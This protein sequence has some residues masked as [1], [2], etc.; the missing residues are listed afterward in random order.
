MRFRLNQTISSKIALRRAAERMQKRMNAAVRLQHCWKRY[1][2]MKLLGAEKRTK[3]AGMRRKGAVLMQAIWRGYTARKKR[4]CTGKMETRVCVPKLLTLG[5]RLETALHQLLHGRR[6]AEVLLASHTIQVCTQY[7]HEC[8]ET[9]LK[10]TN[11]SKTIYSTIKSLNRSRP[12][13][14]LLHQLLLVLCNLYRYERRKDVRY[15]GIE[16]CV[17]YAEIL[18]DV[19]QIHRDMPIVFELATELMAY[20]MMVIAK[21]KDQS[22]EKLCED[23]GRRCGA[24]CHLFEKKVVAWD[25][26]TSSTSG[27]NRMKGKNGNKT[28]PSRAVIALKKIVAICRNGDEGR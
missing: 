21:E 5:A 27:K 14:E 10:L 11:V 19:V 3:S 16:D 28:E 1:V 8:C 12:H 15:D 7:S 20:R 9:C 2:R 17:L 13:V 18:M 24:L 6:L 23:V 25:I 26:I 22:V 4:I